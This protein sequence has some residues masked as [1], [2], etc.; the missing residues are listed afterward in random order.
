M[1][2]NRLAIKHN[3]KVL[4]SGTKP[5]PFLVFLVFYIISYVLQ[6]FVYSISGY[7][8]VANEIMTQYQ[9]GNHDYLPVFPPLTVPSS[10]ILIAL[11]LMLLMLSVG[12]T[13]YF[14]NVATGRKAGYG[15]LFDGFA[16]FGKVLWLEILIY[17]FTFLWA[18]LLIIPGIIAAYRYRMAL[19]IMLDHPEYSAIECIRQSK[20]M[21]MGRKGELFVLD[22]SFLGWYLLATIPFVNVFVVP[23]TGLTYASYYIA[24]RDMPGSDPDSSANMVL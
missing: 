14:F 19:Y 16:I 23:Y 22:L 7:F 24:L 5:S 2:I 9:L 21:M 10:L 17:V 20:A 13:I 3:S 6:Y 4:L 8:A 18:M 15:N 12:M 11:N 1:S